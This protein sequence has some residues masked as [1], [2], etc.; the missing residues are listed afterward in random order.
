MQQPPSVPVFLLRKYQGN[1]RAV[2]EIME[3]R[4]PRDVINIIFGDLMNRFKPYN[5]ALPQV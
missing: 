4:N 5:L 1:I 3:I 2:I